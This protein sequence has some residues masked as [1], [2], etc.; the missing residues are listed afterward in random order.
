MDIFIALLF[1]LGINGAMFLVAFKRKTDHL[2]DISYA[3]TFVALTGY[4]AVVGQINSVYQ[5]ILAFMVI[6]W[7]VRIGS[8]LL[9]RIRKMGRDKRFDDKRDSFIKFGGFWLLQAITVWVVLLGVT[10]FM[11]TRESNVNTMLV[12]IGFG[13][14]LVGLAVEAIADL[15]KFNFI[16]DKNNKG[17][18]IDVGLW[19]YSRHPNYFGEILV[20]AGVFV[21]VSSVLVGSDLLIALISPVFIAILLIFVSGIPLL[22]KSADKRWGKDKKYLEYRRRTSVLV[23]AP[24]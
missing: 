1:S 19:K 17:R 13:I 21:F 22:E 12:V 20:W 6:L 15:Q 18:W 3:A 16:N 24:R 7:A 14:W 11:F 5:W 8:Y 2:T 9:M 23:I 4:A 10:K